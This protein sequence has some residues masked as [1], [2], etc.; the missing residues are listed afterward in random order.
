[1][2]I[3]NPTNGAV[4]GFWTLGALINSERNQM[5]VFY[6][7]PGTG[8][9]RGLDDVLADPYFYSKYP[10]SEERILTVPCKRFIVKMGMEYY[11]DPGFENMTGTHDTLQE[12]VSSIAQQDY[13]PCWANALDTQTGIVYDLLTLQMAVA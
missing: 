6:F 7:D 8:E 1:M 4:F 13:S 2:T 9:R 12:A 11:P 3:F 5:C 10:P